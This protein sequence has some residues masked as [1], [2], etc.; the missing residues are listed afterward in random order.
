[1]ITTTTIK[2]NIS[3]YK[4]I[5]LFKDILIKNVGWEYCGLKME[6]HRE[7]NV[8]CLYIK[9]NAYISNA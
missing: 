5:C 7:Q 8:L 4:N 1:M 9:I 3:F 2:V 6:D